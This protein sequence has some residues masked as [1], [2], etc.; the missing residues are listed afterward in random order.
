M[1]HGDEAKESENI[2]EMGENQG[3]NKLLIRK[4]FA[5]YASRSVLGLIG[6]ACYY[7]ADTFFVARS[8]GAD[9]L[10]A[11]NIASP[12]YYLIYAVGAMIANGSAIL[13]KIHQTQDKKRA[14]GYFADAVM[15]CFLFSVPFILAGIFCPSA[16]MA[17]LGGEGAVGVLG[18]KYLRIILIFAP[19]FMWSYVIT[20]YV[21][22]D[23]EPSLAMAATLV[24]SFFNIV[25]DYILMFPLKLGLT[26]AALATGL[27]PL[28]S[29][30]ICSTHF[31]K[32]SNTV[33]WVWKKP[34]FRFMFRVCGIGWGDF[35]T[36]LSAAIVV[37]VYNFLILGVSGN[38]GVAAYG[39]I[40]NVAIFVK[41]IFKGM[42]EGSQPLI[43]DAYGKGRK[44]ELAYL[45]RLEKITAVVSSSVTYT[46]MFV[47]AYQIAALFNNDGSEML[48]E[49]T[50]SGI[51]LYFAAYLF[52]AF[53]IVCTGYFSATENA[54][55]AAV[56]SVLRGFVAIILFAVLM[57]GLF[58]MNGVWLSQAAAE[59]FTMVFAL[60]G[61]KR[62]KGKGLFG[63][64]SERA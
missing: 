61:L 49:L 9:G 63:H 52:G 36:E 4:Q 6:M 55:W 24:S 46:A 29:I 34:D 18:T 45:F 2:C 21:R 59:M 39:V 58:G 22:N 1:E 56:V 38:I 31:F 13:Y 33:H 12:P 8:Q 51:R 11:L 17:L 53:N 3:I 41:S 43:S 42:A 14:R 47:F 7:L 27:S 60:A 16:L 26:G 30:L 48:Q 44:R 32:K 57:A 10:A 50:V 62:V 54:F 64:V 35:A 20:S 25:G 15:F 19:L 37:L 23:R 40:S 5:V 28:V